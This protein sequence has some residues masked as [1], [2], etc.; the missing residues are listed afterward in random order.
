MGFSLFQFFEGLNDRVNSD[1][2]EEM[3][4]DELVRS[5]NE[6]IQ[7]QREYAKICGQLK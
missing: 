5:L 6:Y 3:S 7:E 2:L 4:K 1:H